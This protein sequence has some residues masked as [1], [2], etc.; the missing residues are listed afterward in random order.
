MLSSSLNWEGAKQWVAFV[1]VFKF[2]L[3]FIRGEGTHGDSG[4]YSSKNAICSIDGQRSGHCIR[5]N[6]YIDVVT[7]AQ[8]MTAG[9]CKLLNGQIGHV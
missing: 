4:R 8:I 9:T 1:I 3:A 7:A 6:R 5:L 2:D